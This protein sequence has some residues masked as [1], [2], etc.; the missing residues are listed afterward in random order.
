MNTQ[1]RTAL[2]T[3]HTGPRM[4]AVT[5]FL[6][7]V[8]K[9]RKEPTEEALDRARAAYLR[10]LVL[11]YG[12]APATIAVRQT[13]QEVLAA[14]KVA[15][16]T[17]AAMEKTPGEKVLED[18]QDQ[19]HM[20]FFMRHSSKE[21]DADAKGKISPAEEALRVVGKIQAEQDAAYAAH[22]EAVDVSYWFTGEARGWS[23]RT[24]LDLTPVIEWNHHRGIRASKRREHGKA[25]GALRRYHEEF[26]EAASVWIATA[27]DAPRPR[28]RA[29]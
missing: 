1:A 20:Q 13:A 21:H 3:A 29:R 16:K 15:Q 7:A 25:R 8:E 12:K 6:S 4:D 2:H 24:G 19:A 22:A 5:E 23:E 28:R 27:P 17:L 11:T 18:L 26:A 9:G 10:I 14:L